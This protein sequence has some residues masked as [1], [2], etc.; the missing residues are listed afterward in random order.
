M[1][2]SRTILLGMRNALDK[3]CGENQNT[4]FIFNKFF[5]KSCVCEIMWTQ[6]IWHMH[7][8]CC[9]NW[10]HSIILNDSPRQ[11]L[12][13]HPPRLRWY[14]H[15]LSYWQCLSLRSKQDYTTKQNPTFLSHF[16][17]DDL[18]LFNTF[19]N[20]HPLKQWYSACIPVL[21]WTL[22]TTAVWLYALYL[23]ILKYF[24]H[25]PQKKLHRTRRQR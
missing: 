11:S 22:S 3:I 18:K 14:V 25:F 12:R 8:A 16:I 20:G 2:I 23:F 7:I 9:K 21:W 17:W 1:V 24:H 10:G 19:N 5:W 15:C 4:H 6:M 13:E